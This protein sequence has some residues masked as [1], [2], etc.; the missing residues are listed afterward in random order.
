MS[1]FTVKLFEIIP[2]GQ[3]QLVYALL[4][5]FPLPRE[6]IQCGSRE[7]HE[8]QIFR[9]NP[10]VCHPTLQVIIYNIQTFSPFGEH[11]LW[12]LPSPK[13]IT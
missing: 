9:Q 7:H 4:Q 3:K 10:S 6:N 8:Q 2:P 1:A 5:E 13:K 12:Q 11:F